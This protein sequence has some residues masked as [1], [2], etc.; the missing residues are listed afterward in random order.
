MVLAV[1]SISVGTVHAHGTGFQLLPDSAVFAVRFFYTGGDPMAY[2]QIN[3]QGPDQD[4]PE[5]Q[6]GRTDCK[7]IFAF[8]PTQPGTWVL[9]VSDGRGHRVR[10][11][12]EV[13]NHL[14]P[15]R[16]N[17]VQTN[18]SISPGWVEVLAG[19]SLLLNIALIPTVLKR[20][21]CHT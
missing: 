10:A 20:R 13:A 6:N 3:I 7:G 16:T 19:L 12:V 21:K 9:T 17:A 1:C 18:R 11:N 15:A 5:H 8:Y 14:K 4:Q 2:A